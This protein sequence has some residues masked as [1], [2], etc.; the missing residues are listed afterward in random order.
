M[1]SRLLFFLALLWMGVVAENL[2]DNQDVKTFVEEHIADYDVMVFAKSYC[3]FCRRTKALL[4]EIHESMDESWTY[5]VVDLDL[6]T[7]ED[8]SLIQVELLARTNQRTVPSIWIGGVHIGGNSDLQTLH[9][10]HEGLTPML[11]ELADQHGE[12]L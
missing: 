5:G 9:F 6:M 11:Q 12:D 4:N 7:G 1:F 10:E 2:S 8:G 3:G